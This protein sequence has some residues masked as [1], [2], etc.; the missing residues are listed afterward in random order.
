LE[1]VISQ[2]ERERKME[3]NQI[4][5]K[6]EEAGPTELPSEKKEH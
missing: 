4:E 6:E 2:D 1:I 5:K 3:I